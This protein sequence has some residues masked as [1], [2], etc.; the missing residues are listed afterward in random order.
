MMPLPASTRTFVACSAAIA[1]AFLVMLTAVLLSGRSGQSP[2]QRR[3]AVGV[4]QGPPSAGSRL[5]RGQ[6]GGGPILADRGG[7][8]DRQSGD[9]RSLRHVGGVDGV[10]PADLRGEQPDH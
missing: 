1:A 5:R 6:T 8:G 10:R 4:T 3:K 2:A 9:R 7:G